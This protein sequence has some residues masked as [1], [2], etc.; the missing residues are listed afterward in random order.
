MTDQTPGY[1]LTETW[2]ARPSWLALP[3]D[4]R[5]KFFEEKIGP[6]IGS[7][8]ESGAEFLSCVINNNDGPERIGYQYMAIWRTPDKAFSD[9]LEAGAKERG[10]LEY[11]D[12]ANFSGDAISVHVMIDDMIKL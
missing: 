3:L 5:Q 11:F 7:M 6:F 1:I 10:F 8:V 2:N 12:Q 9:R 4:E